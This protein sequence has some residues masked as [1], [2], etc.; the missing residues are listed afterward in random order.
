MKVE[1]LRKELEQIEKDLQRYIKA[2]E[3]LQE[4]IIPL[5][6]RKKSIMEE[7]GLAQGQ[8]GQEAAGLKNPPDIVTTLPVPQSDTDSS[9]RILKVSVA[10]PVN[11]LAA[12]QN[13]K[14][15]LEKVE[16]NLDKTFRTMDEIMSLL[17]T[18]HSYRGHIGRM[19]KNFS[20][21][22]RQGN[23]SGAS[24]L[25][26]LAQHPVVRNLAKE[27]LTSLTKA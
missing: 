25:A 7:L 4:R 6:A 26:E 18:I 11:I 9:N 8:G 15:M 24:G 19:A 10:R 1:E 21:F 23:S 5:E 27:L 13:T 16:Q 3:K 22:K 2:R 14:G 17:A 20:S 12:L